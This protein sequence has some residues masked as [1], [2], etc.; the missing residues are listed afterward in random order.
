[1]A[2]VLVIGREADLPLPLEHHFAEAGHRTFTA[3]TGEA[4]LRLARELQPGIVLLDLVLPDMPGTR[5]AV[6]LR[7]DPETRPI[8][9]LMV[10]TRADE[11]DEIDGFELGADDFVVKPFNVDELLRRIEAV[12]RR[13]SRPPNQQILLA[14]E[15]QV[16]CQAHRVTVGNVEI[17]LA[18]LEFK[19]LVTLMERRESA[20]GRGTLL[21]DVWGM[22]P[23]VTTRTVDT[24]VKR[25]R[26]KLGNAGRF[27]QTVRGVG[28][29]FSETLTRMRS[30]RPPPADRGSK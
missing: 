19:L 4:G 21:S 29:R 7:R 15:L 16:D 18:A 25:L 13:S 17:S 5:V 30:S 20:L 27:L 12:L 3:S 9:I 8:P 23:N 28:Y 24:H 26:G 10:T 2:R 22:D 11:I 6:E 1:M 14:E